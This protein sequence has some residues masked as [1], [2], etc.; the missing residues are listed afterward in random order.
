MHTVRLNG[1][2]IVLYGV[3]KGSGWKRG[4]NYLSTSRTAFT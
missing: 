2:T 3:E 4:Q 1:L